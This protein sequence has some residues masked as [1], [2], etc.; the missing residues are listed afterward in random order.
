[1]LESFLS[2]L[3]LIKDTLDKDGA[4]DFFGQEFSFFSSEPVLMYDLDQDQVIYMNR[5]FETEFQYTKADLEA[6]KYSVLALIQEDDRDKFQAILKTL[7]EN[8]TAAIPDEEYRAIAKNNMVNYYCVRIRKLYKK[9]YSIQFENIMHLKEHEEILQQKIEELNKSNRELEEFAYV[10][11]H[12]MQEPLRKISTFGHRLKTQFSG[13][14]NEDA[15]MYLSRM[16]GAS[17]NMRN[18]IDNLLEFSKVSRSKQPYEKVDL[19]MLLKSSMED[20]DMR[21]DETGTRIHVEDLPV[22]EAI[23]SQMRQLLFNLLHNAIKFR[24]KDTD[25]EIRIK[26]KPVTPQ[27][28]KTYQLPA[29][30]DYFMISIADNGIGFEQQYAEKIFQLFQRLEG[31]SEYPGTGIGLSICRKIVVNHKGQIFAESKPGEG[32]TFYIILPKEQ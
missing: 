26:A 1:M 20:L 6:K 12:D 22:I 4:H 7:K 13:D 21:I 24:K 32:T 19:N 8:N 9:F 3:S 16:L 10:A 14:L 23:P 30:Q 29:Q 11:S 31:K 2:D 5:K 28:K 15:T 18:L 17:E 27:E 25:L